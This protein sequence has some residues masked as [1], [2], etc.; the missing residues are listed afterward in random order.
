MITTDA[1]IINPGLTDWISTEINYRISSNMKQPISGHYINV[2]KKK[3]KIKKNL[4]S[5]PKPLTAKTVTSETTWL[6]ANC[7]DM[8]FSEQ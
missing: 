1:Q 7:F 8:N 5:K 3:M 2:K 6:H 4:P